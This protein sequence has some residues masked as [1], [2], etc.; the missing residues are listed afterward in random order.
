MSKWRTR[1]KETIEAVPMQWSAVINHNGR[2][3][4]VQ[5]GDYLITRE[6]GEQ[7][8]MPREQ[9]LD[10][11]EEVRQGRGGGRPRKNRAI[12]VE[13]PEELNGFDLAEGDEEE[14]E[15]EPVEEFRPNPK[16]SKRAAVPQP[17]R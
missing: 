17:L 13:E 12:E 2:E 8:F 1:V 6:N 7:E 15:E 10:R 5:A 14:G 4:Q 3:I 16:P 9:F 11:Y